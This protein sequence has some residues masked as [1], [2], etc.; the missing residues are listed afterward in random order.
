MEI[1]IGGAIA[2]FGLFRVINKLE[3]RIKVLEDN[4]KTNNMMISKL[5]AQVG[6]LTD[7]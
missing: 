7:S 3:R 1:I 5:Q 4:A 2:L 6:K